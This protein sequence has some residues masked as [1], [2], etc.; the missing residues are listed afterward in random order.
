MRQGWRKVLL[1]CHQLHK[2]LRA[3]QLLH[4][5]THTRAGYIGSL[6]LLETV[7]RVAEKL[8]QR[9]P[10]LVYGERRGGLGGGWG[11]RNT[12]SSW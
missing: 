11:E 10:D 7:A 8:R 2:S 1:N 5:R 6:S 3:P 12:Q 4:G 9:N